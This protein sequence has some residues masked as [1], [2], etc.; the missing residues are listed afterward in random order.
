MNRTEILR[1]TGAAIFAGI[2]LCPAGGGGKL[3]MPYLA[4]NGG[5]VRMPQ[6]AI[7]TRGTYK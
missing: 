5:Y 1:L 4:C 6:P 7:A 2:S 3:R